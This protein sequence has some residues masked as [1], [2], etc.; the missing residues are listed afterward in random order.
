MNCDALRGQTFPDLRRGIEFLNK[1]EFEDAS[2]R[3]NLIDNDTAISNTIDDR[4]N[5][6]L[7]DA[8]K[9]IIN[10]IEIRGEVNEKKI[11]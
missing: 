11:I 4:R 7:S 6:S 10:T 5:I 2:V 1:F 3:F 9:S 8:L